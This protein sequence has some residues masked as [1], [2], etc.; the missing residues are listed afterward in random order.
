MPAL[1]VTLDQENLTYPLPEG[2]PV[3]IGRARECDI[4]LAKTGVSRRHAVV[5]FRDGV[6]GIKDLESFNGTLL[7]GRI[8]DQPGSLADGD[9]IK[10]CSYSIRFVESTDG[11]REIPPAAPDDKAAAQPRISERPTERKERKP[12]S[13]LRLPRAMTESASVQHLFTH[14]KQGKLPE[15][16]DTRIF[17]KHQFRRDPNL[18][19]PTQAYPEV[20]GDDMKDGE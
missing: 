14:I 15:G 12:S 17:T 6:C 7:N 2:I 20:G 8:L 9:I 19:M 13:T 5:I 1:V 3:F 16:E 4:H 10:I 18:E 11:V